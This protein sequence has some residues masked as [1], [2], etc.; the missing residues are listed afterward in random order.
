MT[1]LHVLIIPSEPYVPPESRLSGVFQRDQAIA[2]RNAGMDVGVVAV[3][4]RSMRT[5]LQGVGPRGIV[6]TIED[7]LC[8]VRRHG[9]RPAA[10]RWGFGER[11]AFMR[12]GREAFEAYRRHRGAPDIIHAHNARWAG[13]LARDLA[14]CHGIPYAVTEH[15]STY[16]RSLVPKRHEADVTRTYR[17]AQV[18]I[19]VSPALGDL[20]AGRFGGHWTTVPNLL[21]PIF[22]AEPTGFRPRNVFRWI[23]IG[24]LT[25]IKAHDDLITAFADTFG[26]DE[27]VK[28]SI[29]GD[30]PLRG[31]LMKMAR[32][33]GL[34][35][36]VEFHGELDRRAL[37][38]LILESDALVHASGYETFGVAIIEALACGKPVVVTACGGPDFIVHDGDGVLV[39][40]GDATGLR[41]A[42][43]YVRHSIH[44]YDAAAIRARALRRFGAS[45][46]VPRLLELYEG[47]KARSPASGVLR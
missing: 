23:S 1:G 19:A 28:L 6:L 37:R 22:D 38:T 44:A 4:S 12:S 14:E 32:R 46:V 30:G 17:Q 43:R 9:F 27:H 26:S 39:P 20:L 2:L 47:A 10:S 25:P 16:A 41:A 15:S 21:D 36:R 7:D 34:D 11:A 45:S 13:A 8:V 35:G 33:L 31:S 40:V 24:N 42:L 18:C 3:Q 29:V 5:I